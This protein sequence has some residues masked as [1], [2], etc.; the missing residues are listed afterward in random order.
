MLV[1]LFS[2]TAFAQKGMELRPMKSMLPTMKGIVRN[3]HAAQAPRREGAELVTPPET[4]T[5]ETWY[6][7]DG[8]FNLY[9]RYGFE[10]NTLNMPSVDVAI[11]GDDLYI[12]GLSY[13]FPEGWIKGTISGNTVVFDNGQLVGGLDDAAD[14]LVGGD[15][16][17]NVTE[18][19]IFNYDA[20]EGI[21]ESA[22]AII[23]ESPVVESIE[24]VYAYWIFPVF[25]KENPKGPEVIVAPEGLETEEWA[26]SATTNFGEPVYG[27]L[28]IGFDGNDVYLQGLCTY[29]PEAWIKGTLNGETITFEGD[30]YFGYYDGG[31][32]NSYNFLLCTD[33]F[34][35]NYD[36]EAGKMT[37]QGEV[38][39][40]TGGSFLK[41][42]VYNDPVITKVVEKAATPSTPIITQL[43]EGTDG[44][45]VM[46]SIP[47]VDVEG[48][49]M[50]S[51]KLRFKFLKD[52]EQEISDVEFDVADY[53][54]MEE[55]MV[56]IPYG[57]NDGLGNNGQFQHNYI[58]LKQADYNLWN[59]LGIQAIYTG[60]DE[61]NVSEVYWIIIKD[62]QKATFN[63]NAMTDEPCSS[64]DNNQGDIL[65][66]RTLTEGQV[67]LTISPKTVEDAA[68]NRFWSTSNGP[69]LRVYSGTLTFEVPV[70]KVITKLV[71]N[72]GKWN[73]GNTAD[74][75]SFEGSVWTGEAKKVVVTI[76]GNT[77]L[78]SIDVLPA[79]YVPTAVVAPEGLATDTY[80]FKAHSEKPYYDPAELTLWVNVGFDGDDAY[81]QGLLADVNTNGEDLWVKATKNE[82]GQYVIPAN[83]YMGAVSFWMNSNEYYFTAVDENNNMVD[84]VLDFDEEKSEFTT[85]QTLIING[86]LA[87][88]YAYQTFTNVVI[89]KFNE[90]A[91]TPADPVFNNI[92]F[93]EWSHGV[94]CSIP[95]VSTE[96][97]TLNPKKLFYIVYTLQNGEE[98]PYTFTADM[99]YSFEEDATEVPYSVNYGSWDNAHSIYFYD[100]A[101]VFDAWEKVGVQSIYYGAGE[102]NTSNIVWIENPLFE[103][104][105]DGISELDAE[106]T[107]RTDNV[108]FN[109]AGQRLGA[110]QKGLNIING[111]KVVM[112]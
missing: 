19:I 33:G 96:G 11:D 10:D 108:I 85:D 78:N 55:S 36:A 35:L 8:T 100:D 4:A 2:V 3:A 63:F 69:Q 87:E 38:F 111:R 98:V 90:V 26:I 29:L 1:A 57:F 82:A 71:F 32:M 28:N 99:Y 59:K 66:D 56:E 43:Y 34:V 60:G 61:E 45:V 70:G 44:H 94:S 95:T 48:N 97:E 88:V 54:F 52:I 15:N 101:A 67:T 112:K 39:I 104:E 86:Q 18:S 42:D 27:Y 89:T 9:G 6:T 14:Y 76:A 106:R 93:G 102:R 103:G 105:A 47:T 84:A 77:Q 12:Q 17:G 7:A 81:I 46:F 58:Y 74:T 37:G 21:L 107:H 30:Q 79:D 91:A 13:Y 40:Y 92:D 83:Q 73:E 75:G 51:S 24:S 16:Q 65:E 53:P 109:L 25:T 62:Y 50:V 23:A 31:P 22:T 20:E 72:A 49:A 110:P 5:V 68:P 41:G 64:N 80:V